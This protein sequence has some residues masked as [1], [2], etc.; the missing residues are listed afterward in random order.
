MRSPITTVFAL[1]ASAT[2]TFATPAK[3]I[4]ALLIAGGCCHDYENQKRVISEGLS[5]RLPVEWTIIHD[6]EIVDGKDKAA[7]RNHLS[8]AY[9]KENWAAGYDVVVHDECYGAVKDPELLKRVSQA[10]KAG[11]PAMFIHCSMHSYRENEHADLWRE[12]IG[13][14][15]TSHE[16]AAVQEVKTLEANHPVMKGFPASWT[17]PDNEELYRVEKV[18]DT[19]TPLATSHST[20]ANTDYPVIWVNKLGDLRTFSTTLGHNTKVVETPE[21]LDLLGRGLLWVCG[22]LDAAGKPVAGYE[23]PAR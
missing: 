20:A 17:T 19:T 10:H 3:P 6:Q 2:L 16:K 14:R 23:A 18:W 22:K 1:F 7:E 11:I 9:Q 12:L 4:R 5:K 21:Y 8:S 15:S 13:V